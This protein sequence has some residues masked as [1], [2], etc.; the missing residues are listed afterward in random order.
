[1]VFGRPYKEQIAINEETLWTRQTVD[2]NSPAALEATREVRR[3][4]ME[5][6]P[7]EAQYLAEIGMFGLPHWMSTY[8][9]LGMLKLLFEGHHDVEV[10]NYR[11]DLDLQTGV[12]SVTYRIRQAMFSREVFASRPAELLVIRLT[13][14]V[15]MSF[16]AQLPRKFDGHS[17]CCDD[18]SL[19]LTGRCGATGVRFRAF[20]RI[21]NEGGSCRAV[22]DHLSVTGTSSATVLVGVSSDFT[23][24]DYAQRAESVVD[25]ASTRPYAA[26]LDDHVADHGRMFGRVQFQLESSDADSRDELSTDAR[27]AEVKAGKT[28]LGL[29]VD[30]FHYGRYLLMGSSR[31]GTL[32][33]N[34]QG[35]WNDAFVPAWDS[36]FTININTE[37][38]YWPVEVANLAECHEPLFDLIDRMRVRGAETA[39]IHYGC[40]GFTAHHNTD[41]WADCAPIDN[42]YCGLWPMGA[43]WLV[44]H[45]WEHYAFAPDDRFL[46]ER[47]Y[48]AMREAAEFILDL[49][50]QDDSG[51]LLTGPS[52]SPE[53]AYVFDGVRVTICMS[54]TMD[55]QLTRA[56]FD[57]CIEASGRLGIDDEFRRRLSAA[58]V[59]LPE[60]KI[61]RFDQLQEWLED[62]EEYEPGHRHFSHLFGLFPDDQLLDGGPEILVAAR[63]SIER[64]LEH[65]G[66]E[67]GWSRSWAAAL[68]ARLGEGD[69]AF[70]SLRGLYEKSTEISLLD[71]H[72]PQGTNPL[73][74]FQIDGNLGAVAAICEMLLQSHRSTIKLLPALPA[75]WPSGRVSGL[76]ARGGFEVGIEWRD[77]W[78]KA[79]EIHSTKGTPCRLEVNVPVEIYAGER[80]VEINQL[81]RNTVVF[82]TAA[83]VS[84]RVLASHH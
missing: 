39:R 62:Y 35:I 21:L 18:R 14:D 20:L 51:R 64:R 50:V 3:L 45:L 30:H 24:D 61:G 4:L 22:G 60:P 13:A 47:A 80:C 52:M 67:G 5:G 48:P 29:V 72:P 40:G 75:A 8:Q 36:K 16:A 27:L 34:L 7:L 9:V 11:R 53:N 77:G 49:I 57:R 43:A 32:P 79:A 46:R 83:G 17:R 82:D 25:D 63:R 54:P 71:L 68:W 1:M 81:D 58:K 55:V 31:P 37:M 66:G 73:T 44:L 65:G 84:Y 2:R 19:E 76:R 12:A 70:E 23:G 15:P 6:R 69:R 28:D 56:L 42:V 10:E 41:A 78:L 33:A 38:N 74:V 59:R 26:L